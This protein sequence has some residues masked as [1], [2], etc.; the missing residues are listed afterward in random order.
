MARVGGWVRGR[1]RTGRGRSMIHEPVHPIAEDQRKDQNHQHAPVGPAPLVQLDRGRWL[2][3][4]RRRDLLLNAVCRVVLMDEFIWVEP[5]N[6]LNAPDMSPGVEV[7]ATRGEIVALD[8]PDDRL[9]DAGSLT[10]LR[11]G[12][13]GLAARLR[14][15]ITNAHATPPLLN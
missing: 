1:Q 14:Q 11:N 13:T 2:K 12:E 10:D 9:P 7:A 8:S 15:G 4:F 5:D 3:D 6:P